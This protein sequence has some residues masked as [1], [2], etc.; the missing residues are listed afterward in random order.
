MK[1]QL[2]GPKI[3]LQVKIRLEEGVEVEV[4]VEAKPIRGTVLTKINLAEPGCDIGLSLKR[5]TQ[6]MNLNSKVDGEFG[7]ADIFINLL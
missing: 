1:L 4:K 6:L 5:R 7:S 2:L 3:R